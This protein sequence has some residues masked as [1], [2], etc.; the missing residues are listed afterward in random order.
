MLG[1]ARRVERYG[2]QQ[3]LATQLQTSAARQVEQ[4]PHG[5]RRPLPVP[6]I[7]VA[8]RSLSTAMNLK[9]S[10]ILTF[11]CPTGFLTYRSWRT[12]RCA[13]TSWTSVAETVP[14]MP[15]CH[16]FSRQS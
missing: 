12:V 10:C 16:G 14:Q 7:G 5:R 3:I 9:A 13:D 15:G 8:Q 2:S 6:L 11:W 1:R 4:S